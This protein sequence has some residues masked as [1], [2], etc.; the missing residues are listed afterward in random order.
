MTGPRR[1]A[2]VA[3]ILGLA[4]A[5]A[6]SRAA[7]EAFPVPTTVLAGEALAL[8]PSSPARDRP[9]KP[10]AEPAALPPF[11]SSPAGGPPPTTGRRGRWRPSTRRPGRRA[12]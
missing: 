9:L 5:A 7:R 10:W 1:Q 12:P 2:L 4:L 11:R 6:P 8:Q 3:A